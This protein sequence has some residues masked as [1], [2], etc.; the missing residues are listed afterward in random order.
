MQSFESTYK[1][2]NKELHFIWPQYFFTHVRTSDP[3]NFLVIC[4]HKNTK[5]QNE[6]K[7]FWPF[8]TLAC[9]SCIFT[10][11]EN[12]VTSRVHGSRNPARKTIQ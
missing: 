10:L 5:I 9:G 2:A 12:L 3:R 7:H 6:T 11:S 1:G 4:L 8:K